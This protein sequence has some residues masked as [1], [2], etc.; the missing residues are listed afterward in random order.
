MFLIGPCRGQ[1]LSPEGKP[2]I[3][4]ADQIAARARLDP[5]DG[6]WKSASPQPG[7][8]VAASFTTIGVPGEL[9]PL[10]TWARELDLLWPLFLILDAARGAEY[11]A[12]TGTAFAYVRQRLPSAYIQ[13]WQNDK[14]FL[15]QVVQLIEASSVATRI[16]SRYPAAPGSRSPS[17]LLSGGSLGQLPLVAL[18]SPRL[19]LMPGD[20]GEGNWIE[21]LRTWCLVHWLELSASD[22]GPNRYLTTVTEKL[23]LAADGNA[24]WLQLFLRLRG[25]T[26][27]LG[28][29]TRHLATTSKL[30]SS[31]ASDHS[32]RSSHRQLLSDLRSF[33]EGKAPP[34]D[35]SI[36][37]PLSLLRS[38]PKSGVASSQRSLPALDDQ[39]GSAEEVGELPS[40]AMPLIFDTPNDESMV[41]TC[42]VDES[43]TPAQQDR[44]AKGVLLATVEQYQYLRFPWEQ[45]NPFER[46]ALRKWIEGDLGSADPEVR[47]LACGVWLAVQTS[48]SLRTVMALGVGEDSSDDWKVAIL[49]GRLHRTP[50]RRY[51]GWEPKGEARDWIWPLASRIDLKLPPNVLQ[52]LRELDL[53]ARAATSLAGLFQGADLEGRFRKQMQA[54]PKLQR[55]TSGMLAHWQWQHLFEATLDPVFSQLV[56]SHPRSGL[57]G[58]CA[59][60]SYRQDLVTDNLARCLSFAEGSCAPPEA[61]PLNGAGSQLYPLEALLI[62][63]F[64]DARTK[65]NELARDPDRWIEHHNALITYATLM[66]LTATA[67]RPVSSPFEDIGWIDL[68]DESIYVRD[69]Q[70]S[71]GHAG[72]LLPL[73]PTAAHFIQE[74]LLPHLVRM[75]ALLRSVDPDLAAE[76]HKLSLRQASRRLPLL[77][78][79]SPDPHLAWVEVSESSLRSVG[80]FKWPLP[81]NLMRHRAT[82]LLKMQGCDHEVVNA[83][84]DHGEFGT[85]AYGPYSARVW[86]RD[87]Q[88][89]APKIEMLL[90]RLGLGEIDVPAWPVEDAGTVIMPAGGTALASKDQYGLAARAS[91]RSGTHTAV[92]AQVRDETVSFLNGRP[93]ESISAK[94][95]DDLLQSML[96]QK[97][98]LPHAMGSLRYEALLTW[99]RSQWQEYG[100]PPRLKRRYTPQAEEP[101]HFT[102]LVIGA[103]RRVAAARAFL[104]AYLRNRRPDSLSL[105]KCMVWSTLSLMVDSRVAETSVLRDALRGAN[106]RMVRL[107][108]RLHLEYG[109]ALDKLPSSPFKRYRLHEDAARLI[110]RYKAANRILDSGKGTLDT[111]LVAFAKAGEIEAGNGLTAQSLVSKLEETIAQ[112]NACELPGVLAGY[113]NGTVVSAALP[114]VDWVRCEKGYACD[115]V[116]AG[117]THEEVTELEG[118]ESIVERA[119]SADSIFLTKSLPNSPV[120][121]PAELGGEHHGRQQ[122]GPKQAAAHELFKRARE[123]VN[124]ACGQANSAR[125]DLERNLR[126]VTASADEVAPTCRMLVEWLRSLLKRRTSKGDIELSSVQRYFNALSPCFEAVGYDHDLRGS[127]SEEVTD[128]YRA[129][130]EARIGQPSPDSGGNAGTTDSYRSWRLAL[131]LLHDFHR[132]ARRALAIEDPDWSEI[133]GAEDVLSISPGMILEKEYQQALRV[134]APHGQRADREQVA[135][136]FI[137]LCAYRFGLRGAEA[138][139]LLRRDWVEFE[140]GMVV[141]LVRNNSYRTLKTPSG[142]RKVP[143]LFELSVHER[144]LIKRLFALWDNLSQGRAELPLLMAADGSKGLL[145]EKRLRTEVGAAIKAVTMNPR[146][147]LHHAR[148]AFTN[149]VGPLLFDGLEEI[150][151]HAAS[152]GAREP[153]KRERD[154]R[155]SH[156]RRLLLGT[157]Q[158]TRRSTWALARLLGHAHP[159]TTFRSYAHFLPEWLANWTAFDDPASQTESWAPR[160]FIDLDAWA[161]APAYLQDLSPLIKGQ[162]PPDRVRLENVWRML[163]RFQHG[164][165]IAQAAQ[166]AQIEQADGELVVR[167][168]AQLD[169]TLKRRQAINRS[170]GGS[171]NLLS[172]ISA[173]RWDA[174]HDALASRDLAIASGTWP[175]HIVEQMLHEMVGPSRQLLL[176]RRDHFLRFGQAMR[177]LGLDSPC[178]QFFCASDSH[179]KLDAWADEAGLPPPRSRAAAQPQ[180]DSV[181]S[182]DPAVQVKFRAA[183][184]LST[185]NASWLETSYEFVTVF[186]LVMMLQSTAGEV[187]AGVATSA[188]RV[189]P[190][191]GSQRANV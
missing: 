99:L 1:T 133:D 89:S 179:G 91:R 64:K 165:P 123:A 19:P 39:K 148:H 70:A 187:A 58:A 6:P 62:T 68:E 43:L 3:V 42:E 27:S 151:P 158:V 126:A 67:G 82:S 157:D 135:R 74:A 156:V 51:N 12:Q 31:D 10:A 189:L 60:A 79:L 85:A 106:L 13:S 149:R 100:V 92:V 8:E 186:A 153:S 122:R 47:G 20:T 170:L 63:A 81:W 115:H 48:T 138:T 104:H 162:P 65:V 37:A 50:P 34:S 114:H 128:F 137:L 181:L 53:S 9:I 117:P 140:E 57:P 141:L 95:W 15:R 54:D 176:W 150:W 90:E 184:T 40:G 17:D 136:A 190:G 24:Q 113:L 96:L 46:D 191:V 101:L 146:L 174:L 29:M 108:G 49:S 160:H 72:R 56:S 77:F 2:S 152:Q 7:E 172:H 105:R 69:K 102:E 97:N 14:P 161:T 35:N 120:V 32:I 107:N 38:L 36:P 80:I 83:F 84:M 144:Q 159:R 167:W 52:V 155:R 142:R 143:L 185:V 76:V 188:E 21:A 134:L 125:R 130:M 139:G 178:F 145:D 33:C 173:K 175:T 124:I 110:D 154:V 116:S 131:Q 66:L 169:D 109:P 45:P 171:T 5:K 103:S 98:G 118:D 177:Q 94:Q 86:T 59:Y 93:F 111:D 88:D 119:G 78:L 11:P 121:R 28:A 163:R 168:I 75:A 180:V 132:F 73:A 22:A 55:V 127:D 87:A 129:V 112:A 16:Y 147:S 4:A 183:V 23:R 166:G 30:I 44:H 71:S 164:V 25:P 182:G 61:A 26:D 18:V 41:L